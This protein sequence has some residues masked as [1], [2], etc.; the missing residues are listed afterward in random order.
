M[1]MPN[2]QNPKDY[3]DKACTTMRQWAWEFLR[4]NKQYQEDYRELSDMWILEPD[5]E[6]IA[7]TALYFN[8]LDKYS[9][10]WWSGRLPDPGIADLKKAAPGLLFTGEGVR[11]MIPKSDASPLHMLSEDW[12]RSEAEPEEIAIIFDISKPLVSQ[13]N[14]AK[15]ILETYRELAADSG[16]QIKKQARSLTEK[17]S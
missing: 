5:R 14:G 17:F 6:S 1:K 15:R 16:I 4:R 8:V 2:W 12:D 13:L 11:M 10:W 7:E 3:P 9:I